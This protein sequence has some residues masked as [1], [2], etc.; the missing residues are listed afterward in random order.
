ME[1]VNITPMWLFPS[2]E[3]NEIENVRHFFLTALLASTS[4]P[5]VCC[6]NIIKQ[7]ITRS[8]MFLTF[9]TCPFVGL[10]IGFF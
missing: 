1:S 8:V 3:C 9:T 6:F 7:F 5:D 4:D 2:K 10:P